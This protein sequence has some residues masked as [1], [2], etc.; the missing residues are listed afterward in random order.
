MSK[1]YRDTLNLPETDLSMKAGLPRKEPEILEFWNSINLYQKIRE[2]NADKQKFILHDGPPYANGDIHL[3][4]AVN[5]TLKDI[6]IKFQS[7]LGKD[8]PYVP[9]WDCHGLPIELNVEK[10]HGK[11]SDLVRDK[12]SFIK[13]CREY[14][15]SQVDKQRKDFIRLGVLGDW[16]NPYLSL[17]KSFEADTVRALGRIIANGHLEQGEK[18]VHFC[19]DCR[20]ALAEAEVEY[21]DKQSHSIDVKFKVLPK[22][23]ESLCSTFQVD[24][25]EEAYFVIWT[26]TPWTIPSNVAVCIHE[27]IEYIF[28]R[29]DND[30][31][32]IA[33]DLLDECSDRWGIELEILGSVLGKEINEI[34]MAHPLYKR[35]SKLLHGDH[36]TT[37]SGT[38]C[39]HTAPAHG[40]DDYFICIKNG[41]ESVKALDNRGIFKEEFGPLSGLSTKKGDP[42]VIELL[43]ENNALL[44]HQQ[45]DHS[46]PHCWRHKTPLI[47]TSS[48]DEKNTQEFINSL[49][50]SF[51][52][53]LFLFTILVLLITP[54]FIF[55]FAPGFYY[56]D[57]KRI[58]AID[59]LRIMFPY[60]ALISLVSFA[61]GIQNT[62]EKFSI[63]A[64]TPLIFN[65]TLI[66]AAIFI[67][68]IINLPVYALASLYF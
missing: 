58:I 38:G 16:E 50:G 35:E 68:P 17:N 3:G 60:L 21:L 31:F 61:S 34:T 20:S 7:M 32:I 66:I 9:G 39:V 18:P 42:I 67:A 6:T 1:E 27:E 45:Y 63:P 49:A 59:L 11:G 46:Y 55:I 22:S 29:G 36:V 23:I 19:M 2:Q 37:E 33:K 28:V 13:A 15:Q 30:H 24:K 65:I 10:K 54:I 53:I 25:V 8:A 4:H 52:S 43:Q 51:L 62:H 56:D 12:K 48:N 26:T 14:A 40:L 5:K 57:S 41:L 47:F 44:A 64:F